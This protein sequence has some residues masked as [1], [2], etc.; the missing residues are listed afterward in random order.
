MS[1]LTKA[2]TDVA[3]A[4][5]FRTATVAA[6][7]ELGP[8]FRRVELAGDG[9]RGAKWAPG[10]KVQLRMGDGLT[11]R[12]YTPLHW[13][14][15]A[16][17]TAI[18]AFL[19]D[20]GPGSRRLATLSAGDEVRLFGPR[21]STALADAR[22]PATFVGDETS[23]GLAVN[24][25]DLDDP[26]SWLLEAT[27]P[28]GYRRVLA[29][30][31]IEADVVPAGDDLLRDRVVTALRAA[32]EDRLILTGRAQTI[33]PLRAAIKAEAIGD[34]PTTVKAYWDTKRAGLD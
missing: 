18:V 32:P 7:D 12:T 2:L 34:R 20:S 30:L 8:T 17:T 25:H 33:A 3:T 29:G 5:F 1:T 23:V 9:L 28:D 11:L 21:G 19:H 24:R 27:D 14:A 6:V 22:G 26:T 15:E 16:G 13:D 10:H 4:A 31:G